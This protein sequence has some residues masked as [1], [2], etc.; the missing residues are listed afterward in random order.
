MKQTHIPKHNFCIDWD[1]NNRKEIEKAKLKYQQARRDL[2]EIVFTESE[3]VVPCFN[4]SHESYLVRRKAI[5]DTQFYLRAYD[6]TGD[7]LVVWDSKDPCEVQD[8]FKLYQKCIEKGWRA[9]AK[10]DGG[11]LTKRI[12]SFDSEA[13]EIYFD[14][15]KTIKEK[16]SEFVKTF[17][18]VNLTPATR[19]GRR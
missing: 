5:A 19:P 17:R 4:P 15:K 9:Y 10:G 13:E 14:E 1:A 6:E 3:K 11:K 7:Q 8:A 12:F 16:L 2:R 18:E